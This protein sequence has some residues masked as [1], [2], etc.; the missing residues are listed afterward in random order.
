[1]QWVFAARSLQATRKSA[2]AL[3]KE[4]ALY[5]TFSSASSARPGPSR[6]SRRKRAIQGAFLR[7]GIGRLSRCLKTA[8]RED[9][10][11]SRPVDACENYGT[12]LRKRSTKERDKANRHAEE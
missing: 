3:P 9:P 1:M 6:G 11:H 10:L 4:C 5:C 2:D 12:F 8:C 7:Q